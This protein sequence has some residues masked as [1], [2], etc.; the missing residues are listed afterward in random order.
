MLK[1]TAGIEGEGISPVE[2]LAMEVGIRS[3]MRTHQRPEAW[4]FP[5]G[6]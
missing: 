4:K 2:A 3:G 1:A 5:T 6:A